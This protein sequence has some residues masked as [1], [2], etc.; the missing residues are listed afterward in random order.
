MRA[1][2]Q[3]KINN[4][5]Y[6]DLLPVLL[7]PGEITYREYLQYCYFSADALSFREGP[8][9]FLRTYFIPW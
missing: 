1:K 7:A 9:S 2:I 3:E 4:K 8:A 5:P 6:I